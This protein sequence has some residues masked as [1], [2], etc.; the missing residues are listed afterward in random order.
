[1]PLVHRAP[2]FVQSVA[3]AKYQASQGQTGVPTV[4]ERLERFED[5]PFLLYAC[6]WYA[7]SEGVAVTFAPTR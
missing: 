7:Y 3:G 6:L 5:D 2:Q 1:M 4:V